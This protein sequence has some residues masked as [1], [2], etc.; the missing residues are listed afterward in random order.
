MSLARTQRP[1]KKQLGQFLTPLPI[2]R[3][4]VSALDIRLDDRVLEPSFGGG[5]FLLALRE[6]MAR[7]YPGADLARW[8]ERA[9]DGCELDAEVFQAFVNAWG[10]TPP[11]GCVAGDFFRF[12]MP[13]YEARRYFGEIQPEYDWVIGN[14]PFGGTIDPAIQDELD[15]IF[16]MRRGLKIKKET[17]AFFIVKALDLL[18][19]GGRL[20]FIC[21]DTLLSIATM[22]GLRQYLME[23]C[24]VEVERLPGMF[25]ETQQPMI[26]LK[27][28]KGGQ[29]VSIFGKPLES[30]LIHATPNKSWLVTPEYAR[31]F[32]GVTVGDYLVATSGMTVGKNKLFLR[33]IHQGQLVEPYAF[34]IGRRPITV[35]TR[36]AQ[37]R[38]GKLSA[39][40]RQ[41]IE[42]QER[43]GAEEPILEVETLDEPLVLPFPNPDYLPYNKATN[44]LFYAPPSCAIYWRNEGEAVY[45]F[46]QSGPWYLHGVGGKPYFKREGLTWQLI[47]S[48]LNVRYLP[49]GY[50]LDSGAPCA[51]LRPGVPHDE[52]F[53]IMGWC[54]TATC[55]AILKRVL[56]HTRNIQSKDFERLPYPTWVKQQTRE[57][58]VCR[59][60]ALIEEAR[61]GKLF[62]YQSPE[63]AWF[64]E[65]FALPWE[66]PSKP[67]L[68][69]QPR[70]SEQ[71]QFDF[72]T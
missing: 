8:A 30:A 40:Q 58:I 24:R 28:T 16:G 2:A 4:I 27:L 36:L 69:V 45:T 66:L 60:K 3:A 57:Q 21:S 11:S 61:A 54:V 31:F 37:A 26:L 47:S 46:K 70:S 23:T 53:F 64:E 34:R 43:A 5:A 6:R 42:K 67:L 12:K 22:K 32:T 65:A 29:G 18:K 56:N 35:A 19:P 41:T 50:I 59:V 68:R 33:E 62:S 55:N 71:L 49:A 10:G 15:A 51:F 38:L 25:L 72:G 9:L 39:E 44:Q 52:L 14:P 13:A 63:L 20:V 48:H 1:S 7:C 17:Y